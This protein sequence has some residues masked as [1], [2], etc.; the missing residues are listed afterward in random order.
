MAFDVSNYDSAVLAGTIQI[1][2][3]RVTF[4]L[5]AFFQMEYTS[6]DEYVDFDRVGGPVQQLAPF[7]AP[8][9]QGKPLRSKGYE[10]R[11]YRP[12]YLKP[13]DALDPSRA[14]KR[15][16]GE[17]YNNKKSIAE[18]MDEIV[19]DTQR[20][21]RDAIT[22]RWEWMAAQAII[23]GQYTIDGTDYPRVTIDFKRPASH[24][25]TNT[26][27]TAWDQTTATPILDLDKDATTVFT[28]SGYTVNRVILDPLA[29]ALLRARP[30][31]DKL[32]D[33]RR[34]SQSTMELG[35]GLADLVSYKG[36]LGTLEIWVFSGSMED[37]N[38]V[39][40]KVMPDYSYI[41]VGGGSEGV[42]GVRCYGAIL[43]NKA[44]Y[45]PLP[46]F[47]KVFENEDPSVVYLLSQSAPLMVVGRPEATLL[48]R[49]KV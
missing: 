6:E 31:L 9:V 30:E 26:G 46:I 28:D 22:N 13:K 19:V 44:G 4:F 20:Q 49:V 23:F 45:A 40:Q 39:K 16:P 12:A 15:R 41:M 5:E 24:T 36:T 29:W 18:R 25:I 47:Q 14:L 1:L 38:G 48:R 32:L 42:Y 7:V 17:A 10:T 27:A 11:R 3:P 2:P 34:G 43:D 35:P 33:T 8:N 21:H 37:E